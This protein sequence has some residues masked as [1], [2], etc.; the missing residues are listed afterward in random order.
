MGEGSQF[1]ESKVELYGMKI[2]A[3]LGS[4]MNTMQGIVWYA[5]N[6]MSNI[7]PFHV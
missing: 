7:M 1:E 3:Q 4:A 6:A 2:L 5:S